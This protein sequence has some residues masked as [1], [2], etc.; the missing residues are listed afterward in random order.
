VSP[1]VDEF[2]ER[3]GERFYR[4]FNQARVVLMF[5]L[6]C[7][8]I[9]YSVVDSESNIAYIVVGAVLIG[10]VPVDQWLQRLPAPRADG[11]GDNNGESDA[12]HPPS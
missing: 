1:S 7:V 4:W 10:L 8:L 5:A 6:G 2:A 3:G 12:R 11:N 9:I